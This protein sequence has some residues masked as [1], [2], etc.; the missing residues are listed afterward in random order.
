MPSTAPIAQPTFSPKTVGLITAVVPGLSA[1]AAALVLG[2]PLG[3]NV[4]AGL[5]LVT[6]G[7]VF[8]VCKVATVAP[9]IGAAHAISTGA[10]G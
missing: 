5:T 9:E 1:L 7:I 3:W 10:R 6:A 4:V 2:E 8:G